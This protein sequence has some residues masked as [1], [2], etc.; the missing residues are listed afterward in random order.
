MRPGGREI[1]QLADR[2]SLVA[3]GDVH[4]PGR[5][6]IYSHNDTFSRAQ[7]KDLNEGKYV[8]FIGCG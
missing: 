8:L 2:M 6:I 1:T 3:G 4:T 5:S 7:L